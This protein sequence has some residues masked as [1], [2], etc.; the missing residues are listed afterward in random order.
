MIRVRIYDVEE[1]M[2]T[3]KDNNTQLPGVF[4]VFDDTDW[5]YLKVFGRA[6]KNI[7]QPGKSVEVF[8]VKAD[9]MREL[10]CDSQDVRMSSK[11][12]RSS[13]SIEKMEKE[14]ELPTLSMIQ[15]VQCFKKTKLKIEKV[16]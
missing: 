9:N 10:S 7:F 12:V 8:K 4:G 2:S 5:G 1:E 14:E 16:S 11:S 15:K 3:Q 6:K 13:I